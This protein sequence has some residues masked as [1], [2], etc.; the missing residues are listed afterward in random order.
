M[1]CRSGPISAFSSFNYEL[2]LGGGKRRLVL[3]VLVLVLGIL[4]SAVPS[5]AS[6]VGCAGAS[7]GPFDFTSLTAALSAPMAL[8]NNTITV[9]GT[10]TEFVLVPGAQTYRSSATPVPRWSPQAAILPTSAA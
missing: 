1:K 6:T 2:L 8:I 3:F 10:C 7:G 5:G 4:A 9:S